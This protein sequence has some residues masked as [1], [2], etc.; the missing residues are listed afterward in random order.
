M[1]RGLCSISSF[2]FSFFFCG[3]LSP[4]LVGL[5]AVGGTEGG[6]GIV[7]FCFRCIIIV[8]TYVPVYIVTSGRHSTIRGV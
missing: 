7:G 4:G 2:F 3:L 1:C 8:Y 5:E 6:M